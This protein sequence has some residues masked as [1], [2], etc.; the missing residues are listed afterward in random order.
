M[1]LHIQG[2]S[3]GHPRNHIPGFL[4][5]PSDS[6]SRRQRV[7][8]GS[9]RLVGTARPAVG[10]LGAENGDTGQ[11]AMREDGEPSIVLVYSHPR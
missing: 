4:E 5:R 3:H 10:R 7:P 8:E 11:G 6:G 1:T 2:P 9:E